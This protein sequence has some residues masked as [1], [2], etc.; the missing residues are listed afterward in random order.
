[1]ELKTYFAQDRNGSLIPSASV[2]IF[3]TGTT[4]LASGLTSVSGVPLPNPFTA[5][6]DGKI[7]FRAPD[8]IYDMQVSLGSTTGV[9]VTFQCV[10]VEQQ[11][12]DANS[13]ASR[14][15]AAA[16]SIE[17][18]A[19]SI[20]ANTREQWRRTLADAGFTLVD[21]SFEEGATISSVTDAVWYIAGAKCYTWGGVLP[22]TIDA[23]S[24]PESTGG[25]VE[26]AW[27][28]TENNTL[29]T[30]LSEFDGLKYIGSCP[31][32]AT[33]RTIEPVRDQQK[34]YVDFHT[35]GMKKTV[36][37]DT[38]GGMFVA[39]LTDTTS[40]DDNG[41]VIVT[42]GGKRWVRDMQGKEYVTPRMFGAWM[43]A[44]YIDGRTIQGNPYPKAPSM[45][46]ADLTDVH[47]DGDAIYSAYTYSVSKGI[48]LFIDQPTFMGTKQIDI[49]A[50]RF[51]GK[52]LDL[53]GTTPRQ[54][55]I[56]TSGVGGFICTLWA[57]N[58]KV[59]NI[60]FR[61]ADSDYAGC[62]LL[63]S[64]ADNANGIGG[65]GKLYDVRNVE[66]Y[67]YK[68]AFPSLS[69]VSAASNL[70]AYD[71]TYG[72]AVSGSTS[73]DMGP[74]WAHHCNEGFLW[75]YAIDRTTYE[76]TV[77]SNDIPVM[78][79]SASNIAADGCILPHR[80]GGQLRS[81]SIN[82]MGIEGINGTH[83]LDFSD[84]AGTDDQFKLVIDNISCWI[85]SSMNTGVTH[86]IEA[87]KNETRMPKGSIVLRSGYVKADYQIQLINKNTADSTAAYGNAFAIGD[88]FRFIKALDTTLPFDTRVRS[89]FMAGRTYGNA[90][91]AAANSYD[92]TVLS[93]INV[94]SNAY[95]K[96]VKTEQATFL[97]PWNRAVDILL[98]AVG[99]ES[100]YEGGCFLAGEM[101][102]IPV[103]KNGLGGSEA[104]GKLLFSISGSSQA[105]V[106]SGA[107]WSNKDAG[108]KS[109]SGI[110]VTKR[111]ADGKT[112]I[113]V[114]TANADISMA[115][116]HM[117]L[118]YCGFIHYYD[119]RWE[120]KTI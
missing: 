84:Y 46:A 77:T 85:Q 41:M 1:M 24:T 100:R 73:T 59:H 114:D 117:T 54:S 92:G 105:N 15:E 79:V 120:I 38:G 21:G 99:E 90:P 80:F 109:L 33:L 93:A 111:I 44:P 22:K 7:Q 20:E 76:P 29:G 71:C 43:D 96:Q 81:V 87:P 53:I 106:S 108:D 50:K 68:F 26:G 118:T 2:S 56:Y 48:S 103:N 13:S 63:I 25:V 45:G 95:F 11:L 65:G 119:R 39:D 57:H 60:A 37:G 89:S 104:G 86:F 83:A 58:I 75:G 10:D 6:A 112:Y 98:T 5:D 18:Q 78:Y 12:S 52:S 91:L 4:T 19:A 69:F 70:Y 35:S 16:E 110:N 101:S 62:P 115:V 42:A 74:V 36:T 3:L 72:F 64:S 116:V 66:F 102:I 40:N 28:T 27:K 97:L 23:D 31:D 94:N 49:S 32:I 8:G 30:S 88:D 55:L 107:L 82:G 34:I 51:D 9:K 113:R 17:E 47:D 14:A 61:N 67:H